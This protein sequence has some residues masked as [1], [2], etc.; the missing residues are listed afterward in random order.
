MVVEF[1]HTRRECVVFLIHCVVERGDN[2]STRDGG[3]IM[4]QKLYNA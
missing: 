1:H 4:S 3:S 2:I